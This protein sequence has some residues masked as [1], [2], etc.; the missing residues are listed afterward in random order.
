LKKAGLKHRP[1][2][3]LRHSFASLCL[4]RG[5]QPGWVSKVLGHG[6]MQI[7]FEHYARYIDNKTN[8]NERLMAAMFDQKS[9]RK[10]SV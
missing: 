4:E 9:N 7:T 2:Y 1:S 3:Q 6:S 10:L 5:V 8:D